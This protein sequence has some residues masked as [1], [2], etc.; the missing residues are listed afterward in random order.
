MAQDQGEEALLAAARPTELKELKLV[1]G[2]VGVPPLVLADLTPPPVD[3]DELRRERDLARARLAAE[4]KSS[5]RLEGQLESTTLERDRLKLQAVAPSPS[6]EG[7][8]AAVLEL[9]VALQKEVGEKDFLRRK[10]TDAVKLAP[11]LKQRAVTLEEE[12][13]HCLPRTGAVNRP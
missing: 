1:L 12:N 2:P 6:V 8:S 7:S 3:T 13:E 4:E 5:K 9:Q 11:Q 10:L